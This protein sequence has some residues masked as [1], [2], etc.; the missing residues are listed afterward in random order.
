M[1]KRCVWG[2]CN[3]DDRYKHKPHISGVEFFP[4]PKPKTK[5]QETLQ[6]VKACGRKDFTVANVNKHAYVCSKHFV[7]GR[8]TTI[9]PYS[10]IATPSKHI[11]HKSRKLPFDR[12]NLYTKTSIITPT[13]TEI[14][15]VQAYVSVNETNTSSDQPLQ[16]TAH[17]CEEFKGNDWYIYIYEIARH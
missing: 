3:N 1:V 11:V 17:S 7:D 14:G 13:K 5:L 10:I 2:T 12:A 9:H 8:P 6:W 16:A 4:I 15:D